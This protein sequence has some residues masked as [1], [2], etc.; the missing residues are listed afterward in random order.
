[1]QK[2]VCEQCTKAQT[3]EMTWRLPPAKSMV[4]AGA[5]DR[6]SWCR[7]GQKCVTE[8]KSAL[9]LDTYTVG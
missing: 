5:T 4:A 7:A 3:C 9:M 1:M 8:G 6:Q 2:Q